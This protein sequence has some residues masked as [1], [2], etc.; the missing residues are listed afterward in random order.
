M[1]NSAE[2]DEEHGPPSALLRQTELSAKVAAHHP[3]LFGRLWVWG[4][5]D[6]VELGLAMCADGSSYR[7][8]TLG[9]S[10][11]GRFRAYALEEVALG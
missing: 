11:S 10:R 1:A 4:F 7:F 5:Y 3:R 8:L 2:V 9:D 6:G